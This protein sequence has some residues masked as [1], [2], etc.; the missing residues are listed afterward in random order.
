MK[1]VRPPMV[2]HA[3][4]NAGVKL[5]SGDC[6]DVLPEMADASIHLVVTDPPYFLDRLDDSWSQPGIE[7]SKRRA[8]V[9]GGLPVGMK[10]DRR[11]AERLQTFLQPVAVELLRVLKPGGFLLLFAA[12]RLYHRAA[13][14]VEDA[15]FEIRDAFAWHFTGKAQFKAFTMNHFVRR[16][17]DMSS[18]QKA[19]AL[20][21]LDGRR[22]PQLRPQ[23]E[24]ILCAQKPREGTFV[25]NWL[26]HGTGL[27]DSRQSLTGRVPETV[28]TVAK[29]DKDSANKHLTPKPTRLCAH[30]IRLFSAEGQTVLDPFAGSGTV[31]LAALEAARNSIG[32]D[33]NPDYL[34]MARR[35][36]KTGR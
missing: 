11:Q 18:A 30:L 33:V 2:T 8:D 31:C 23:F 6:R 25:D 17:G 9:I 27:I 1:P 29:A 36:L 22:T 13:V 20:K 21:R 34:E 28:M 10:F 5:Y 14:A 24:M 12:P 26:A 15:G 16:R 3:D 35:R 32:I 7:R 19:A 4:A